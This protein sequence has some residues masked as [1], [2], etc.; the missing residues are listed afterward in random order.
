M[1]EISVKK[2]YPELLKNTL[3]ERSIIKSEYKKIINKFGYN[4]I[5]KAIVLEELSNHI[6]TNILKIDNISKYLLNDI[7]NKKI[8]KET[9]AI[10]RTFKFREI[11]Y[12][13]IPFLISSSDIF[14][15]FN[16]IYIS[17]TNTQNG[18]YSTIYLSLSNKVNN[19]LMPLDYVFKITL[20]HIKDKNT[21]LYDEFIANIINYYLCKI[22]K[23]S[24]SIVKITEFGM[25]KK[26]YRGVYSI[27]EKCNF[28]L[29]YYI[30]YKNI[31]YLK[32]FKKLIKFMVNILY[33]VKYLHDIKYLHLDIKLPNYLVKIEN[34]NLLIKLTDFGFAKRIGEKNILPGTLFY[35]DPRI[36]LN[37][38]LK[39]LAGD[40]M[41]DIF[42]LGIIFIELVMKLTNNN[43]FYVCPLL[44]KN[45]YNKL[46]MR[47][48]YYDE[49]TYKNNNFESDSVKIK[50]MYSNI[51]KSNTN[52]SQ[53][54]C[55]INLKMICDIRH[56]YKNIDS[57]ILDLMKIK[58][59]LNYKN[60]NNNKTTEK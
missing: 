32:D 55:N 5:S 35:A 2:D 33:G 41:M 29:N 22:I 39:Q 9:K 23:Q 14:L 1:S 36:V 28:D 46:F 54:L 13:L 21:S 24:K 51:N 60:N 37:N 8:P 20:I 27:L 47:E 7:L 12:I 57:I 49:N 38:N 59:E 58:N 40:K 56:R 43:Y 50:N 17:D 4:D 31:N 42:S 44:K 53:Q 52:I 15:N 10:Y 11:D 26:P 6:K 18:A 25:V 3:I 34:K 19:K 30:K 16:D 48:K 45:E